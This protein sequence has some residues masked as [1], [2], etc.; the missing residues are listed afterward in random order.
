MSDRTRGFS[1][2]EIS[3]VIIIIGLI[4]GGIMNG[5]SL[6]RNVERQR[7]IDSKNQLMSEINI[8]HARYGQWPGDFDNHTG[9]LP[10]A[11]GGDNNGIIS[12]TDGGAGNLWGEVNNVYVHLSL[13]GLMGGSY[14]T[15]ALHISSGNFSWNI[16]TDAPSTPQPM[17]VFWVGSHSNSMYGRA[18]LTTNIIMLTGP[19]MRQGALRLDDAMSMDYKYDDGV[20][21]TGTVRSYR[22]WGGVAGG[23]NCVDHVATNATAN[24]LSPA[25]APVSTLQDCVVELGTF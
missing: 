25:S 4:A 17:T 24:Y 10:G 16:G 19:D 21:D 5:R 12:Y 11:V 15:A 8:F 13:A 14:S 2:I 18:P 1:L 22:P 20:A 7:I 3:I 23:N 6:I 9:A